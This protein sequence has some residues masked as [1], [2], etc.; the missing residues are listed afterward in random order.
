ASTPGRATG[1][2]LGRAV[3][4]PPATA[5]VETHVGRIRFDRRAPSR[6]AGPRMTG[7]SETA[8]IDRECMTCAIAAAS[9]VRCITSPNPWVGAVLRTG[10]GAMYEGATR[11]PGREHAEVVALAAAGAAAHDATLYV[12]LEPCSHTGRTGPCVDAIQSAGVRRVVVG[13]LDPD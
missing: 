2:E 4:R 7:P 8:A 6:Y 5:P 12:T 1:A 3:R 9:R 11:E 13:V 10:D